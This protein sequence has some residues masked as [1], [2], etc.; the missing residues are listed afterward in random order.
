LG[1]LQNSLLPDE[2]AVHT[3]RPHWIV[4]VY[5]VI[6]SVPFGL[7]GFAYLLA[8]RSAISRRDGSAH[9]YAVMAGFCLAVAAA[10]LAFGFVRRSSTALTITNRRVV[11]QKGF[12]TRKTFEV[13]LSWL[14]TVTIE[15]SLLGRILGYGTILLRG[16][17]G[18]VERFPSMGA[19]VRFRKLLQQEWERSRGAE[20][21]G[22]APSGRSLP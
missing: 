2:K 21:K 8:S 10:C 13:P 6:G 5:S 14:A 20:P 17:G 18:A 15:E 1:Y 12:W 16:T 4:L 9:S 3:A 7:L 19:A 22:S 11:A